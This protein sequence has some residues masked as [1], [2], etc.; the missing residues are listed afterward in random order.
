MAATRRRRGVAVT[1]L[2]LARGTSLAAIATAAPAGAA[3]S[4]APAYYQGVTSANVVGVALHLPSALPALPNLPKNLAV[5]LIGVTG[6][7]VH[8]TLNMGKGTASTAIASL[9][10]GSLVDALP[11][12]LGLKKIV[13][14]TLSG[15]QTASDNS[16]DISADPLVNLNIGPLAAIAKA[17][18]NQAT[19]TLTD[20]YVAKLGAL[21]NTTAAGNQA[22]SQI[23]QL[24]Q[25]ANV[26]GQVN[27]VVS[28]VTSA[29]NGI[30]G[31]APAPV[32]Q[33]AQS[34]E[35]AVQTVQDKVNSLVNNLTALAN[36]AVVS[37][38]TL[39][40]AQSIAPAGKAAQALA[41]VNLADLN[42]LNGLLSVKGFVS[43]ASAV[44]N[45]LPGGAK[46]TFSGHAPIV[47]IGTP[48]LTATL[49]E[50]GLNL[51]DVVG[52][53]A[54]V[55]SQVDAAL[56]QLQNV[57]NTLLGTLGVHLNYVPGHVD[58]VD[59]AGKYAAAT[60]P[61]YDI[62]VDSPIPGD[63]ALAEIG[64]GHGTA[65]SV[66]A[67]QHVVKHVP[68][69]QAGALPHTGANLPLIG[70]AGLALLIG[71]GVLRR[72]MA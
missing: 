63:G 21:L 18:L 11:D 65:A 52:L 8:N 49:D 41:S 56:A 32:Q 16:R 38:K 54:S 61:E 17:N 53:P 69:P 51:S 15:Q 48:V 27:N 59:P 7:A 55:T 9:A 58:K 35:Q 22:V 13:K 71:A 19:A 3:T 72:R 5:N 26:Q 12:A 40:A 23:Q 42:V 20:G 29:L 70:G 50:N 45:G 39:D 44:A 34:V 28:Q 46:A 67:L 2:A 30:T 60:G 57:L 6:N 1:A 47:A 43:Q 4:H 37:V 25:Q 62:V 33:V 36:T 68:N 14:A 10:S 24:L 66:S 64:L 31:S